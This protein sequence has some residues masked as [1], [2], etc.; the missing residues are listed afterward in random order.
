MM[1]NPTAVL[2]EQITL[3]GYSFVKCNQTLYWICQDDTDLSE[4]AAGL[5]L[6]PLIYRVAAMLGV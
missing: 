4:V 2:Q 1:N 5:Q 6:G 3:S